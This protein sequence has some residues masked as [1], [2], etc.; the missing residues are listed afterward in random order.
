MAHD[1]MVIIKNE[2]QGN[3]GAMEIEKNEKITHTN[4]DISHEKY[5]TQ[6]D[7]QA[8]LVHSSKAKK[9]MLNLNTDLDFSNSGVSYLS[10]YPEDNFSSLNDRYE[11]NYLNVTIQDKVDALKA[12]F[13]SYE[14]IMKEELKKYKVNY[15]RI[16]VNSLSDDQTIVI[17]GFIKTISSDDEHHKIRLDEFSVDSLDPN[18]EPYNLS[19]YIDFDDFSSEGYGEK[20]VQ[21]FPMKLV[22]LQGTINDEQEIKVQKFYSSPTFSKPQG[23][24]NTQFSNHSEILAFTGPYNLD[25]S[26]FTAFDPILDRIEEAQPTLVILTGPFF[27]KDHE[28]SKDPTY[29]NYTGKE[30]DFHFVD[31]RRNQ[32]QMFLDA[33]NSKTFSK[34]KVA[35]IP[36]LNEIDCMFPLPV[37]ECVLEVPNA[38]RNCKVYSNPALITLDNGLRIG[39]TS[40]DIFL[41]LGKA[42]TYEKVSSRFF[43][44]LE[45]IIEQKNL[46]PI[47]PNRVATDLSKIDVMSFTQANQPHVLI[48]RTTLTQQL[49]S[50]SGV[51]CM[52]IQPSSYGN[53]IRC[54]GHLK[55]SNDFE[56]SIFS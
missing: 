51:V 43:K 47:Y 34:T 17:V 21:V 1:I 52:S 6:K 25:G 39:V 5:V 35:I 8:I 50:I 2:L 13:E 23:K 20:G 38:S 15:E 19:C 28:V 16:Y 33:V 3:S 44:G 41:D 54:Y 27:D 46:C 36:D 53:E 45:T 9:I 11:Q 48:S 29:K 56:V 26:T 31:R 4:E 22:C 49:T 42:S 7:K 32:L 10:D 40:G 30:I 55:V 37:P 12:R 14:A 18:G 24:L